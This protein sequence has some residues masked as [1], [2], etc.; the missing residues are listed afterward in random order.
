MIF[1]PVTRTPLLVR[2]TKS[3]SSLL[4]LNNFLKEEKIKVNFTLTTVGQV[5]SKNTR[6]MGFKS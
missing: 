5:L 3:N 2:I 6:H 1:L 4:K